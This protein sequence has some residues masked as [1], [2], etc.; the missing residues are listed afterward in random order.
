M[1]LRQAT[2]LALIATVLLTALLAWD[3]VSNII[4]V[5]R[6]LVPAVV[7]LSSFIYTFAAFGVAVFLYAFHKTQTA[8]LMLAAFVL[9][10]TAAAP[11]RA[12]SVIFTDLG[13]GGT[14]QCCSANGSAGSAYPNGLFETA[15]S[16]V[17]S[18]N[19][20]L[21]QI[22]LALGS[23]VGWSDD[24]KISLTTNDNGVPGSTL[25]SW[26]V[27][28]FPQFESTSSFLKKLIPTSPVLLSTGTKYWILD[29]PAA[30]NTDSTWNVP[31]GS[32]AAGT[33]TDVYE[34]GEWRTNLPGAPNNFGT[35][36]VAFDVLGSAVPEPRH[37]GFMTGALLFGFAM[38]ALRTKRSPE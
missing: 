21:D 26:S 23:V 19:A 36:S 32:Y 30:S 13:T 35:P 20:V 2:L 16:F 11:S 24:V 22:D 31:I 8:K 25:A 12:S 33:I 34:F 7:I 38:A 1:T 9:F 29:A 17:P 4:N 10:T 14:Y 15:A 37:L 5:V 18:V 3:L 6:G 28:G 27:S